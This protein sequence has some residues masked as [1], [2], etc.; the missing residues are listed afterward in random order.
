[1]ILLAALS[2]KSRVDQRTSV[3]PTVS[4]RAHASADSP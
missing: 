2:G 1:M 4:L 3:G